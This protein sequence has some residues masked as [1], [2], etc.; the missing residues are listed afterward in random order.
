MSAAVG[1]V[2]DWLLLLDCLPRPDPDAE[3]EGVVTVL[4]LPP[5]LAMA[6]IRLAAELAVAVA[7]LD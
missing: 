2:W 3:V 6:F 1:V 5:I 7:F 4:A